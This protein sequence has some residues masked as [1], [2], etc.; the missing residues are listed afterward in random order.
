MNKMPLLT[1]S[2]TEKEIEADIK[3]K[4][5]RINK[6]E[7]E[8]LYNLYNKNLINYKFP[9]FPIAGYKGYVPQGNFFYGISDLKI[10]KQVFNNGLYLTHFNKEKEKEKGNVILKKGMSRKLSEKIIINCDKRFILKIKN[11]IINI[12]DNS[13]NIYKNK[14]KKSL[15]KIC[16]EYKEIDKIYNNSFDKIIKNAFYKTN[17]EQKRFPK[18]KNEIK[19]TYPNVF[20]CL[21]NIRKVGF[22]IE[23]TQN[24]ISEI[25]KPYL[26]E[27]DFIDLLNYVYP[28]KNKNDI[29]QNWNNYLSLMNI[30]PSFGLNKLQEINT[31]D[32][33]VSMIKLHKEY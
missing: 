13:F 28:S 25:L 3:E 5:I 10:I 22:N 26:K 6:E 8:K 1:K 14:G 24:N 19:K 12:D 7:K 15:K 29:P 27:E 31:T 11:K 16:K 23:F 18:K 33:D 4:M 9:G 21:F 2:Q 17:N 30:Y 32:M 20:D